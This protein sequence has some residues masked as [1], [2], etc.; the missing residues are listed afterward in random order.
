MLAGHTMSLV[1]DLWKLQEIDVALDARLGSLE[2]AEAHLGETEELT[3]ARERADETNAQLTQA[4]S[5][6]RDIDRDAED[7]RAKIGPLEAKLYGGSVRQ[8]KELADMQADIEQLKRQLS[9]VEDREIEALSAVESAEGEALVAAS[10]RDATE[11]AWDAEQGELR[12]RMARLRDEIAESEEQRREQ[13]E[14]VSPADLKMYDRL[15]AAHSGR[16]LARLDR[17][18]CT[19]CRISLP[20]NVVTRARSG[21][22][23]VQC[24]N[25]ERILVA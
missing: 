6:Q 15:R 16:A 23:L 22:T 10:E 13:A 4:R 14:Y 11:A 21:S 18:L 12:E 19:G 9:A 1:T 20:T 25:C 7:L 3:A 24:P 17:N 8:P 5:A 2:D